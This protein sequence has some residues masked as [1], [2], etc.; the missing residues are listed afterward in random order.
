VTFFSALQH[1]IV[2]HAQSILAQKKNTGSLE[3]GD[4]AISGQKFCAVTNSIHKVSE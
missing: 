4:S 1:D 2:E 3:L